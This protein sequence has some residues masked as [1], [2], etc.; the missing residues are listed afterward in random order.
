M[1]IHTH[2]LTSLGVLDEAV[3]WRTDQPNQQLILGRVQVRHDDVIGGQL[4]P[5]AFL[6]LNMN[7]KEKQGKKKNKQS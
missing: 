1:C 6:H 7:V 2:T 4:D 5:P 3:L